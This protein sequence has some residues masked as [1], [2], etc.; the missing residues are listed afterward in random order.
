MEQSIQW[1]S[2]LYISFIVFEKVFDSVDREILW[3]LIRH[4]GGPDKIISLI[5]YTYKDLAARS[6]T[7]ASCLKPSK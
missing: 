2:T 7:S 6:P 1:N 3:K 4:C 5:Q